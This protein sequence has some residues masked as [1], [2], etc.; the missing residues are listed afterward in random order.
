MT[1]RAHDRLP[2][3]PSPRLSNGFDHVAFTIFCALP[4]AE[5]LTVLRRLNA[6]TPENFDWKFMHLAFGSHPRGAGLARAKA[7][8]RSQDTAPRT[9]CHLTE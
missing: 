9:P 1:R 7:E 6:S 5:G 2:L 3:G 4:G 8:R